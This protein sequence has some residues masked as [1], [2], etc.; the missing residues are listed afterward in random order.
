MSSKEALDLYA[1]IEDLLG[2]SEVAPRL[3]SFYFDILKDIEFDSLLD[4]GCGKG[5]FIEVL[6]N[7]GINAVGIDKSP[8]MV[9]EAKKRGVVAIE[10]EVKDI[11]EQFDIATATF[12]MV[13]YLAPTEFESFFS[14]VAKVVK[15][16]GYFIFDINS[17]Y[18]ISE[19][20]VGNFIAQDKNRFVAIESFYE[21]RVY[22]SYF[23]L[24]ENNNNCYKKSEAKIF[25]YY[26]EDSDFKKLKD[27]RVVKTLPINLYET[28]SIDKIIYIL[29]RL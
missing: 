9:K 2:V 15:K 29:R 23:T 3:Y 13:N 6:S 24:F 18:G 4:I 27:W 5:E 11:K 21:D 20:A 7:I 1:K 28:E 14:D 10:A 17:L 16:G 22:K 8:L 19:M 26:Y 12:D 25:Q